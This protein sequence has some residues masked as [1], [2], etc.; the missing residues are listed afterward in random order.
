[1]DR[2]AYV[3]ISARDLGD[4]DAA[5][6]IGWDM[7]DIWVN[8]RFSAVR[9]EHALFGQLLSIVV[10]RLR[11]AGVVQRSI[12]HLDAIA[13]DLLAILAVNGLYGAIKP[14][15]AQRFFRMGPEPPPHMRWS[16]M[17]EYE[18]V[19]RRKEGRPARPKLRLVKGA[20]NRTK[21]RAT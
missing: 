14:A 7:A 17:T 19:M 1:M 18:E 10:E 16:T 8:S 9:Q 6:V 5:T 12:P 20:R 3:T 4:V 11:M 13:S 21:A 15:D 2:A